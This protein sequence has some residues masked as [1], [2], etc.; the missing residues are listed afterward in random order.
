MWGGPGGRAEGRLGPTH[1]DLVQGPP[2]E[3][4]ADASDLLQ[5][6]VWPGWPS[7][8]QSD[9]SHD[10]IQSEAVDKAEVKGQRLPR[11]RGPRPGRLSSSA[12][13]QAGEGDAPEGPNTL[14]SSGPL[15]EGPDSIPISGSNVARRPAWPLL[16][17]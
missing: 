17:R 10:L 13:M 14:P 2:S 12:E 5:A 8:P 9:M 4:P 16:G 15:R 7:G 1:P 3:S 6:E 11:A